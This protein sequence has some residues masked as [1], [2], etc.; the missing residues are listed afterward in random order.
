MRRSPAASGLS[1][2]SSAS[3]SSLHLFPV[4]WHGHATW[5][6]ARARQLVSLHLQRVLLVR[7]GLELGTTE[8]KVI[9]IDDVIAVAR[10]LLGRAHVSLV[11]Q[12]DS[13]SKGEGV[14]SVRPLL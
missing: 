7:P 14:G 9:L 8:E 11:Q 1:P 5:A 6:A 2:R 10:Q 12:D 3:A 13:R 4:Q